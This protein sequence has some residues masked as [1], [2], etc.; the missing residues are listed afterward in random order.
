MNATTHK[1]STIK[2]WIIA[3][4]VPTLLIPTIQIV[5][6]TALSTA[7]VSQINWFIAIGAW[8]VAVLITM[9]TNLIN[10]AIDYEKGEHSLSRSGRIKVINAG[11]LP[12]NSVFKAGIFTLLLACAIPVVLPVD[13]SVCMVVI[14]C[15]ICGYCYTG[16][17]YPISYLGLSEIFIFVFYGWLCMITPFYIQTGL[18]NDA[19]LIAAS[20]MGM[21]A[22]LPNAL[23]NFRDREEDAQVNKK[24]LAVHFGELF[25]RWEILILTITPFILN[26]IWLPLGF[27]AA[28]YIPFLVLPIAIPF[29]RSIMTTAVGPAINS[30]FIKSVLIHFSF[31]IALVIGWML[32]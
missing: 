24:T 12:Q 27:A 26:M 22:I 4:R 25:A 19:I 16:G 9:G 10:D 17:P 18:I 6:S 29:I 3:I 31:G 8:L 23:N 28:S 13:I 2:A 15:A 32:Q 5:T 14:L 21:L 1:I 20:Q 7:F 11:L 30:F